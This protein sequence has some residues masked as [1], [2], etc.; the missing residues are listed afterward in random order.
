MKTPQTNQTLEQKFN[1]LAEEW[2]EHCIKMAH[3]SRLAFFYDC[4]AAEQI[5]AMGRVVLPMIAQRYQ[6]PRDPNFDPVYSHITGLVEKI[7]QEFT[8]PD[9]IRGYYPQME[10]YT[11]KWIHEN[12]K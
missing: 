8:I 6:K 7:A 10:D 4:S 3:H 5:I 11:I 9:R 2:E 1:L 12:I